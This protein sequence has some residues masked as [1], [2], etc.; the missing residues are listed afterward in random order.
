MFERGHIRELEDCHNFT[1][2]YYPLSTNKSSRLFDLGAGGAIPI[3]SRWREEIEFFN[4]EDEEI[5]YVRPDGLIGSVPHCQPFDPPQ[6]YSS[7]DLEELPT[8]RQF[9]ADTT[10]SLRR[11]GG[12]VIKVTGHNNRYYKPE[13]TTKGVSVVSLDDMTMGAHGHGGSHRFLIHVPRD[14]LLNCPEGIYLPQIGYTVGI[15]FST[16]RNRLL[17]KKDPTLVMDH[18]PTGWYVVLDTTPDKAES[19]CYRGWSGH[20][21]EVCRTRNLYPSNTIQVYRF[22]GDNK[23]EC[24]YMERI[25]VALRDGVSFIGAPD[26]EDEKTRISFNIYTSF[27]K[28]I[29]E[30]TVEQKVRREY[31]QKLEEERDK[32][33]KAERQRDESQQRRTET[34]DSLWQRTIAFLA[35][36][37]PAITKL[38][39]WARSSF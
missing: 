9:L 16:I 37:V 12:I 17:D 7:L 8:H 21:E 14:I 28:A 32:R 4:Y 31:E 29:E 15:S 2:Y 10:V 13:D 20:I 5:F 11:G 25:E 27:A 3:S 38:V 22:L 36:V 35:G 33:K 6:R 39:K 30:E 34:K 26:G 24:V 19:I 23:P 18:N 1:G